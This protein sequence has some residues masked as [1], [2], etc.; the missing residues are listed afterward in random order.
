MKNYIFLLIFTIILTTTANAQFDENAKNKLSSIKEYTS[1]KLENGLTVICLNDVQSTQVF[2]RAYTNVPE[3]VSKSYQLALLIDA[4]LRKSSK[5]NLPMNWTKDKVDALNIDLQRDE[6]GIFTSCSDNNLKQTIA[7]LIDILKQPTANLSEIDKAK[8]NIIENSKKLAKMP[9]DKIDKITKSIIYGKQHPILHKINV[10]NLRAINL[11]DYQNFYNRFYKPGNSYILVIGN[12]SLEMIK[13]IVTEA[14]KDWKKKEIPE[15]QYKLLPIKEP[16]IVF[17]DTVPSGQPR[18]KIM[19]PFALHPFT[20]NSEK[21]ELL[22]VLFQ[23]LLSDT[24]INKL[25]LANK[26]EAKFESDKIT[27]NYQV[28]VHLNN[29]SINTVIETIISTISK[30]Q[31]I[32]Y[33]DEKLAKA[34]SQIIANFETNEINNKFISK[35][36][37]N[38]EIDNLSKE[39]YANFTADIN[40][41]NKENMRTFANKYLNYNTSLF[42]IPGHWY[43]SLNDFIKLSKQFRIELYELNGTLKKVIPKGYNG[44]SVVND[45]VDAVGGANNINKLKN[46]SI[47][48]GMLYKLEDG[49]NM[50]VRGNFLHQAGN[51]FA[52]TANIHRAEQGDSIFLRQQIFNGKIGLDSTAQGSKILTGNA[53][54]LL[55]FQAPFVPEMFYKQWGYKAD[56]VKAD[57]IGDIYVWVVKMVTPVNQK[58]TDFYNVDNGLRIKRI[59]NDNSYFKNRTIIYG[60]YTKVG[61]KQMIYPYVKKITSGKTTII[62]IIGKIDLKSRIDPD[63]FKIK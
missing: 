31:K 7:L 30:L 56:L 32:E 60:K 10:K 63:V 13:N 1:V 39:F 47:K 5:V 34:K 55:E 18:I 16:K 8:Q 62:M 25:N 61:K 27:G 49:T 53:L 59:I 19:F 9:N 4:E 22:S 24:L 48:Y 57:K 2:V 38:C 42:Q 35:L 12:I 17:F 54:K 37:M 52:S 11:K 50:E 14:T 21:A 51:K 44:F 23:D 33:S 28:N 29:D 58:I 40:N 36:I 15:S 43:K 46:V 41:T 6:K 20:F 3:Y 45:Y 26:I